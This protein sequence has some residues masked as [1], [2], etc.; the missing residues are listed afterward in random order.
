MNGI[1]L[2]RLT[3]TSPITTFRIGAD[4]R[5]TAPNLIRLVESQGSVFPIPFFFLVG[6]PFA[7]GNQA[8]QTAVY[9]GAPCV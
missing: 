7:C 5:I 3:G 1:M 2:R 4:D 6:L 9:I 8:P